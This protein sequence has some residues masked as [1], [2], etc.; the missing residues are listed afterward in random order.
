MTKEEAAQ[1]CLKCLN[2][3]SKK[4]PIKGVLIPIYGVYGKCI[5]PGGH[6]DEIRAVVKKE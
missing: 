1:M 2:R 6:C 4:N 5:R 3:R